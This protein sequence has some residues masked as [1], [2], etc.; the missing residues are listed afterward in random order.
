VKPAAASTSQP[1]RG[2]TVTISLGS[3][4]DTSVALYD[5]QGGAHGFRIAASS[6]VGSSRRDLE[7]SV[8]GD[9]N[10][11][12]LSD[13]RHLLGRLGRVIRSFLRGDLDVAAARA[14]GGDGLESLAGYSLSMERTTTLTMI[15]AAGRAP[16]RIGRALSGMLRDVI[17][18][19]GAA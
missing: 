1:T 10:E 5:R 16:P 4:V 2:D 6:L 9:L 11:R 7:I 19:L 17:A 15:R 13:I 3:E 12:E 14:P 8:Q 18:A